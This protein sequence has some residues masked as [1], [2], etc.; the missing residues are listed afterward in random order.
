ME[1]TFFAGERITATAGPPAV[2]DATLVQ[3]FVNAPNLVDQ[4]PFPGTVSCTFPVTTSSAFVQ[5]SVGPIGGGQTA[6]WEVSCAATVYPLTVTA[7]E[8]ATE[9]A[10]PAAAPVDSRTRA[11]FPVGIVAVAILL[12]FG[13][14]AGASRRRRTPR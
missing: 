6:T 9:I 14:W 3:L 10:A 7:A 8:P 2:G 11:G 4:E 1:G 12:Q 5:W 13:L